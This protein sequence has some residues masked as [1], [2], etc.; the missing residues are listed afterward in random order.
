MGDYRSLW[1]EGCVCVLLGKM[2]T[3]MGVR[4]NI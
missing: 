4:K 1:L 2:M 3:I